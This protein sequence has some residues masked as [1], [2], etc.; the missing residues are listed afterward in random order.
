MDKL[1]SQSLNWVFY[2]VGIFLLKKKKKCKKTKIVFVLG[3][4]PTLRNAPHNKP[5]QKDLL[6]EC[7]DLFF[8]ARPGVSMSCLPMYTGLQTGLAC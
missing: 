1:G 4:W 3:L 2:A 6:F 7:P 8:G 5:H